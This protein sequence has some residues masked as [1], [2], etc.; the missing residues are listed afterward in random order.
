MDFAN[1]LRKDP[2]L[3]TY[4]LHFI[5]QTGIPCYHA[6]EITKAN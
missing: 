4:K 3:T 1:R 6:S 2:L 5:K